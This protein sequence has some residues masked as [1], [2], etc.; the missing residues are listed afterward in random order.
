[1]SRWTERERAAQAKRL[2][3]L[4]EQGIC[5]WCRGPAGVNKD[6]AAR[7]VCAECVQ[8]MSRTRSEI[9]R[10]IENEVRRNA[11]RAAEAAGRAVRSM[12]Q[13]QERAAREQQVARRR[14]SSRVSC[15][16]C[17]GRGHYALTCTTPDEWV[18]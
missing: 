17:G 4:K 3:L 15:S 1:M 6:G 16:S 14:A 5:A 7:S 11:E 10:A 18:G 12:R 2:A 13:A 9:E 8:G